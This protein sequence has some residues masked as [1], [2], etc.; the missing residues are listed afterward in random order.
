M[1][2]YVEGLCIFV[3]VPVCNELQCTQ[4]ESKTLIPHSMHAIH[5]HMYTHKKGLKVKCACE[6][7]L[8]PRK[9]HSSS[10]PANAEGNA[11]FLMQVYRAF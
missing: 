8:Y 4:A 5:I 2:V 7:G 1:C 3:Y 6:M 9:V 10:Y 11:K